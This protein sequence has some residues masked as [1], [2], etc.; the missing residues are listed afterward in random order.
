MRCGQRLA[1]VKASLS[2]GQFTGW[3]RDNCRFSE[4]TAQGYMRLARELPKFDS[5]KAQR[6]A[7]LSLRE[8]L[9]ELSAPKDG[10]EAEKA[11][12][13]QDIEDYKQRLDDVRN[14]SEEMARQARA[15]HDGKK[16]LETYEYSPHKLLGK[17]LA[18]ERQELEHRAKTLKLAEQGRKSRPFRFNEKKA[19][20]ELGITRWPQ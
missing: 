14:R 9:R 6:V 20:V 2:H 16:E 5:A 4:R 10:I 8:A 18:I 7:D 19:M 3:I 13:F 17:D 11:A 15:G 12:L 1:D